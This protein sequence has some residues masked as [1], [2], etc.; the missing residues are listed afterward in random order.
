MILAITA[1]L[2]GLLAGTAFI[3]YEFGHHYGYK[4]AAERYNIRIN[5]IRRWTTEEDYL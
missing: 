4:E 1:T 5:N 2:A 3:A